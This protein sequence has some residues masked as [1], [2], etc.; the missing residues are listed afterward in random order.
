MVVWFV[1]LYVWFVWLY[2]WFV[3]LY[4]WFHVCFQA[5]LVVIVVVTFLCI[6]NMF[7]IVVENGIM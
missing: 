1:W 4:V 7:G 6:C 5:S 2:V 3:W